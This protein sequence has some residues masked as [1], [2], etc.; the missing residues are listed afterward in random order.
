MVQ[1]YKSAFY[2]EPWNDDWSDEE[3]LTEYVKEKSGGYHAINY[4][5]I[6]DGRLAAISLGQIT[7]WWEGTN[8]VL[9]EL[10]VSP[11]RQGTGIGSHFM[12]LI[13]EDLKKRNVKGI[14]LQTDSDKPAYR[15]YQKNGFKDISKHVSLFKVF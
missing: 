7:H 2:G 13:E 5:L 1:L 14:F 3:Q 15:F 10:C 6:I 4:G 9:D 8:Y 12:D 11:D